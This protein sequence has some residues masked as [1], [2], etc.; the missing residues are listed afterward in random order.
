MSNSSFHITSPKE[1]LCQ[2]CNTPLTLSQSVAGNTCGEINCRNAWLNDFNKKEQKRRDKELALILEFENKAKRYRTTI[3]QDQPSLSSSTTP[4]GIVPANEREIKDLSQERIDE[5]RDHLIQCIEEAQK[6]LENKH[7]ACKINPSETD[8]L[9][10]VDTQLEGEILIQ[11]CSTCKGYCCLGG[12]NTFG[13]QDADNM[14]HYMLS[15][16]VYDTDTIIKQY[17]AYLSEQSYENS[18]VYHTEAGCNLPRTMRAEICNKHLCKNLRDIK[19]TIFRTNPKSMFIIAENTYNIV[20]SS[21][22]GTDNKLQEF[23][24]I[25][26]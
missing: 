7:Y 19:G 2:Y 17:L 20:R 15:S 16:G 12:G 4:L 25:D 6:L 23:N 9:V 8:S 14:A 1:K 10:N 18:C 11:A 26:D 22:I 24:S 13:Y 5:F 21:L 3:L